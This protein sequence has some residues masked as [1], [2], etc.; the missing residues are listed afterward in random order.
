MMAADG[1]TLASLGG[2]R[3]EHALEEGGGQA[4]GEEVGVGA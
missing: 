2:A 3:R 1:S 4:P